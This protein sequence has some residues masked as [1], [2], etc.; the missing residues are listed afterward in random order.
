MQEHDDLHIAYSSELAPGQDYTVFA[1]ICRTAR[2]RNAELGIAGVLMFDGQ[3]FFQWLYGPP[4]A[5]TALM[6]RIEAD[7]RH[8]NFSLSLEVRLP[9]ASGVP[10]WRS[11]YADVDA[12]DDLVGLRGTPTESVLAVIRRVSEAADLDPM[13]VRRN[14]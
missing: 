7:P 14:G 4:A 10:V 5:V 6:E 12:M 13:V 11:G 2:R 3:R 8:V 1:A 9:L